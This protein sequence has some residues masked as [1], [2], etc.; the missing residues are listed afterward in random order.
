MFRGVQKSG[1]E[2][3]T[4]SLERSGS[5]AGKEVGAATRIERVSDG[6]AVAQAWFRSIHHY[7]FLADPRAEHAIGEP[8][9]ENGAMVQVCLG[10]TMHIET[11]RDIV[12]V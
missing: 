3:C 4:C 6:F 7:I 1:I 11:V 8:K 12:A 5:E 2:G 9:A 10:S